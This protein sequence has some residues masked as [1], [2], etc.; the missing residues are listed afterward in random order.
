ML[1]IYNF[2]F[3]VL[4]LDLHN[5]EF[6]LYSTI[7]LFNSSLLIFNRAYCKYNALLWPVLTGTPSA[8]CVPPLKFSYKKIKYIA[9]RKSVIHLSSETIFFAGYFNF[10]SRI[11]LGY[12]TQQILGTEKLIFSH[13]GLFQ[14]QLCLNKSLQYA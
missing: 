11:W 14:Q 6:Q 13:L 8:G 3:S 2:R 7:C 1:Y 12:E 5:F 9:I 10:C 4:K